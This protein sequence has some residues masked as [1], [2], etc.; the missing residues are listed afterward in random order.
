MSPNQ[1][2]LVPAIQVR[3]VPDEVPD[4]GPHAELVDFADVYGNTHA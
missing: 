3:N 2:I 1:Q 4:V